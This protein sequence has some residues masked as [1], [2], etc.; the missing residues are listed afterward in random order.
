MPEGTT[1]DQILVQLVLAVQ[2]LPRGACQLNLF[3]ETGGSYKE[4]AL[5]QVFEEQFYSFL[6]RL[7]DIESIL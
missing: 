3:L 4:Y 1:I 5:V 6:S 2:R 7:D